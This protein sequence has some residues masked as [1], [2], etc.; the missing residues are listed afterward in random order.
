MDISNIIAD[1]FVMFFFDAK[2]V[3]HDLKAIGH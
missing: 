1:D 2:A 3:M